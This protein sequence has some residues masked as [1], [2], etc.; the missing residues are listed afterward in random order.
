MPDGRYSVTGIVTYTADGNTYSHTSDSHRVIVT[1]FEGEIDAENTDN[2]LLFP[3]DPP[4]D[5]ASGASGASGGQGPRTDPRSTPTVTVTGPRANITYNVTAVQGFTPSSV[6]AKI[7][8][9]GT[10]IKLI[11]DFP[12]SSGNVFTSS[13]DGTNSAGDRVSMGDYSIRGY[14]NYEGRS[15]GTN[16]VTRVTWEHESST[17]TIAVGTDFYPVA[18]ATVVT[19][20]ANLVVGETIQ[21]DA[22]ASRDP[23]DDGLGTPNNGIS[24][25]HWDFGEGADP[26]T[27]DTAQASCT[28]SSEGEKIATLSVWDND[29]VP[30]AS[31]Q[32]GITSRAAI[33]NPVP[34]VVNL[35]RFKK[36]VEEIVV[37]IR[38]D[39]IQVRIDPSSDSY[40]S[41]RQ[42]L[43]DPNP[44]DNL[45]PPRTTPAE[46]RYEIDP[47]TGIPSN[48]A[49]IEI[50][51]DSRIVKTAVLDPPALGL[52]SY[53]W[54]GTD[55]DG[56][57]V[58][59]DPTNG[60]GVYNV[61]I[62]VTHAPGSNLKPYENDPP[63]PITVFGVE[64]NFVTSG[65]AVIEPANVT[66]TADVSGSEPADLE[67]GGEDLIRCL[68]DIKPDSLD[69]TYNS[70]IN[71]KIEDDPDVAGDSGDPPDVDADPQTT[72]QDNEPR[73]GANGIV[74]VIAS[75]I[76]E[77]DVNP[78]PGRR[79]RIP[80]RNYHL[81]YRIRSNFVLTDGTKTY[82]TV[83]EWKAIRQD[84]RDYIR[85][86]FMDMDTLTFRRP[87]RVTQRIDNRDRGLVTMG[88]YDDPG[89]ITFNDLSCN[90][91]GYCLNHVYH[92]DN[93]V[94][95]VFQ[96]I[97]DEHN[98][99]TVPNE[100]N[101]AQI[102]NPYTGGIRVTSAFRCPR[103]HVTQADSRASWH[104]RGDAFDF[105]QRADIGTVEDGSNW[106]Q[107]QRNWAVALSAEREMIPQDD[108]LL[109]PETGGP[110]NLA[111]LKNA[112]NN[113][114]YNATYPNRLSVP[115]GWN[116]YRQGHISTNDH[117]NEQNR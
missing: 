46:I 92:W 40:L 79:M 2:R 28:Y 70:L 21:F 20:E 100:Q 63:Y 30:S 5:S 57:F 26:Q 25:F 86:Q 29:P 106:T 10:E 37:R 69:A 9:D 39:S 59:D 117:P 33:V 107:A 49:T 62:K 111:W 35:N 19:A 68:A 94:A 51:K 78:G 73:G 110:R 53:F 89:N 82:P 116:T 32:Q 74:R 90:G 88:T 18:S 80:G 3:E 36:V 42:E 50:S 102:T 77:I 45:P 85:Q 83:S 112:A 16:G 84:D 91:L 38:P 52:Q 75:V 13:W 15:L 87:P 61:V 7:Y 103:W 47:P 101:N 99:A 67:A 23:D 1:E 115:P 24:A 105:N 114:N 95:A 54:D 17:H 60:Y 58:A 12:G 34:P 31:Q 27:A 76:P 55:N 4:S 48:G 6:Y 22:S 96:L 64:Y 65:N 93:T 98:A 41:A 66:F 113:T 72:P 43:P 14:V 97:R 56:G 71:W 44:N 8:S 109:Y 104:I 108:I 11:D 81:N